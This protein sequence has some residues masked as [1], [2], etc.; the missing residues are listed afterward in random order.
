MTDL[1]TYGT[2]F[3]GAG[4]FEFALKRVSEKKGFK[5]KNLF[6]CDIDKWVKK[7]FLANHEEP[8]NFY[9]D[10]YERDIPKNPMDIYVTTPPCQT[11][12]L[13]G[14]REGKL[15]KRGIL[16]FN[17]LEFIEVNKP[18]FFI[19]ENVK[20]LLSHDKS[21]NS[22]SKYGKTFS[23]WINLL[24]GKSINGI[25]NLFPYPESVPYHL[26]FRV[27]NSK[28]YGVPQNRERVFIVGI[29]DDVDN[30]FEWPEKIKKRK[31][32]IEILEKKVDEKYYLTQH[33]I[34]YYLKGNEK[35][36]LKNNGFLFEPSDG[37]KEAKAIT[38]KAGSR[39]TDN[40]IIIPANTKKGFDVMTESDSLNLSNP[41]STTRRGRVG[42]GVLQTLDTHCMQ[43]V[44][45][46][47]ESKES[48]GI[49]PYVQNRIYDA[50]GIAPNLD[51][52]CGR[53]KYLI[54][55]YL[56]RL[57]PLECFR[58]Q[59]FPDSF[60]EKAKKEGVSDNQ[61]Y[62]QAGNSVTVKLFELILEK[63]L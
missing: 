17:S 4:A 1:I 30:N 59:D 8:D 55:N 33:Q 15:D 12:S 14:K 61:L 57:T 46:L 58:A 39:P 10:V 29:R 21:K 60:V 3:S 53:P 27:L 56:R 45:Q 36:K 24:G 50:N 32:L 54:E 41:S 62:K 44:I 38:T 25:N 35:H 43:A 48:N 7:S 13:L 26:Y 51:T 47:N 40:F 63:L 22:K 34:D 16:F 9:S 31:H 20:G 52:E 6:A 18:R 19:F 23:E 2:D 5:T 11:F 37:K 49:Q 28:H 42:V